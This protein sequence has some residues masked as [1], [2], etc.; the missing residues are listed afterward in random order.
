MF[1]STRVFTG[2]ARIVN[3]QRLLIAVATV[4]SIR[5]AGTLAIASSDHDHRLSRSIA[6]QPKEVRNVEATHREGIPLRG[7]K[8]A[9]R[10]DAWYA[11]SPSKGGLDGRPNATACER[12]RR[13]G[14]V[15][16]AR[17]SRLFRLRCGVAEPSA[18][19]DEG[20]P[21]DQGLRWVHGPRRCLLHHQI[22]ERQ[23]SHGGLEDLLLPGG[24]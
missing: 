1:E 21:R 12:S 19:S 8:A 14:R 11:R 2:G 13:C 16:F 24:R 3:P 22:L 9:R 7:E 6:R 5:D 18:P 20:L 17:R 4:E 15:L 23:G 10:T